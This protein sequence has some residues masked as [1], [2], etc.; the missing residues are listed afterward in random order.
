MTARCSCLICFP[1]TDI[2]ENCPRKHLANKMKKVQKKMK[3]DQEEEDR[4]K[5]L[6]DEC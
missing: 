2:L 6:N 4:D 1:E 3:I 5:N